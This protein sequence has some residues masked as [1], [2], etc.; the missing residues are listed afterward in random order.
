M[1]EPQA[2]SKTDRR[3]TSERQEEA[4]VI[5]EIGVVTGNCLAIHHVLRLEGLPVGGENELGFLLSRRLTLAQSGKCRRH[6]AFRAYL[7]VDVVAL[8]DAARQVRLICIPTPQPLDRCL[9]VS[10]SFEK[11]EGKRIRIERLLHE[12]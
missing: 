5:R 8:K 11:S 4:E 9:L 12:P 6:I 2:G 7:N 3:N 1:P 10:K